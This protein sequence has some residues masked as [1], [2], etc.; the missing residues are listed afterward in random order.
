M[1]LHILNLKKTFIEQLD[2]HAPL[3]EK[4]IRANNQPFSNKTINK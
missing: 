2:K 1:T 4:S 3:K